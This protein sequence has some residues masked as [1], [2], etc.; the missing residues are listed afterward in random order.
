MRIKREIIT[1]EYNEYGELERIVEEV[2][3]EREEN[4]DEVSVFFV[5]NG[6]G[7]I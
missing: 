6:G 7:F 5:T 3:Y 1:Y 4:L 2:E